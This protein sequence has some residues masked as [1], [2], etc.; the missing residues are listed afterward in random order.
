M[1]T[2]TFSC[3]KRG[4]WKYNQIIGGDLAAQPGFSI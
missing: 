3:L 2:T 4:K 1:T